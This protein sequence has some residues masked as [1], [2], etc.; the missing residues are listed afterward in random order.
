LSNPEEFKELSRQIEEL[1]A[2]ADKEKLLINRMQEIITDPQQMGKLG[3][4]RIVSECRFSLGYEY[5]NQVLTIRATR[6]LHE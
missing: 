4:I 3:L 5:K 6:G 1:Q 2:A